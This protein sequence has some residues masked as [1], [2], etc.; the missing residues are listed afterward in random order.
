MKMGGPV[1]VFRD[2]RTSFMAPMWC[3]YLESMIH[4][5]GEKLIAIKACTLPRVSGDFPP[6][7]LEIPG[8]QPPR[9]FCVCT[10]RSM[11]FFM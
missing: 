11:V 7:F 3:D 9:M 6:D 8:M 2:E 4:S 1:H 5:F 10:M